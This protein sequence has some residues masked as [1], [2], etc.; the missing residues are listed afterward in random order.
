[1]NEPRKLLVNADDYGFGAEVDA[2]IERC[3]RVGIVR[4]VSATACFGRVP[5]IQALARTFSDVSVGIHFNLSEGRPI[6]D[7]AS[8]PTLVDS[9]TG[10]FLGSGVRSALMSGRVASTELRAEL[11][12]QLAALRSAG[13]RITHFDSHQNLHLF[14]GF[15]PAAV[16]VARAGGIRACRCYRRKLVG[17]ENRRR[18]ALLNYYARN[19]VRL[20]THAGGR[21]R[22][23]QARRAGLLTADVLLSPG[24]LGSGGKSETSTWYELARVGWRGIAEIYCHPSEFYHA[25][26][27][28]KQRFV[29]SRVAELGILTDSRLHREMREAGVVFVSF[30]EMLEAGGSR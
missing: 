4:S 29:G 21:L 5:V 7:P 18:G 30:H 26:E 14:P 13:I 17:L 22:T 20:A 12:A 11:E 3:L 2:G 8:V 25:P 27:R 15:F 19:P 23:L 10:R 1:M 24:Y 16:A 6:L 9:E 28:S